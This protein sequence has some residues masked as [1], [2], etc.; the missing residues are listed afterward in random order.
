MFPNLLATN[1]GVL[2]E[3]L[4]TLRRFFDN[5]FKLVGLDV[6]SELNRSQYS[7]LNPKAKRLFNNGIIRTVLILQES[8]PEIKYDI[9]ERLN[10]GAILLNSQELRNC[11]YRGDLNKVLKKL[12]EDP[13]FLD[14]IGLK[15]PHKRFYDS[16]LILRFFALSEAYD[17]KTGKLKGYPNKMKTFLNNYMGK[18]QKLS[19]S[20]KDELENK[21]ILTIEKVYNVFGAPA[22][23]RITPDGKQ[24][25]RL[26]RALMDAIMISFSKIDFTE[27]KKHKRAIKELYKSLPRDDD[28]FYKS[29]IEGTSDTKKIEYRVSTWMKKIESIIN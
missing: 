19:T 8:H 4:N 18:K 11:L 14:C 28:E 15:K 7:T 1:Y 16:E 10:R 27:I 13:V 26:N 25:V 23:R 3:F 22:F 12:R 21:F 2:L 29:I 17:F 6:L 5:E 24:D 20:E 9:F